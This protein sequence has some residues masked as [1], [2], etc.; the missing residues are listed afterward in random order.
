MKKLNSEDLNTLHQTKTAADLAFL[1]K[2]NADLEYENALLRMYVKYE[3]S[4]DYQINPT[5]GE[6]ALR[7]EYK[8]NQNEVKEENEHSERDE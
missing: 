8:N 6:I 4:M 5:T 2:Q 3:I 7:P 1:Q